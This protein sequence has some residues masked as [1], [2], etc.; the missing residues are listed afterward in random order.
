MTHP[1]LASEQAFDRAAWREASKA[2]LLDEAVAVL[3]AHL[4]RVQA[5]L[6]AAEAGR[7]GGRGTR[8]L[9]ETGPAGGAAG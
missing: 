7:A 1:E 4:E 2:G 8:A 5:F 3:S 9:R 6:A